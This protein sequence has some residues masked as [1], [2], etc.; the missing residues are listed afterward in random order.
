[1]KKRYWIAVACKSHV[2]RGVKEGIC[3]VC[4]GK[5]GPLQMMQEGDFIIYYSPT[6]E[7]G[8]KEPCRHFTAIGRVVARAPYQHQMSPDF[9]PWRRDVAYLK[10]KDA[11]IEPLIAMLTFI[12]DKTKWG[13]PF[14]R[15]CITISEQDFLLIARAM[16][17]LL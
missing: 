9:I 4:H 10:A 8:K 5:A 3:Q 15:G 17:V 7:F 2:Q 12:Q 1:M 6:L 13:F 11:A 14:K 16:G